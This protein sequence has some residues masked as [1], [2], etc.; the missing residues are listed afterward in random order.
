[1]ESSLTVLEPV[2]P[3]SFGGEVEQRDSLVGTQPATFCKGNEGEET[4]LALPSGI[5]MGNRDRKMS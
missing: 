2:T 5:Y 3:T 1:M 4:A